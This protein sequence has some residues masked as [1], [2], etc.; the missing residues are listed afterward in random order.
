MRNAPGIINL[1]PGI[2]V[3]HCGILVLKYL[4]HCRKRKQRLHFLARKKPIKLGIIQQMN[5]M[6]ELFKLLF[7]IYV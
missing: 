5:V 2:F 3:S 6:K 1:S 7:L 4:G